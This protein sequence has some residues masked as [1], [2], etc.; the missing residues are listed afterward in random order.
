M[1]RDK[2]QN[3]PLPL[4]EG[5]RGRGKLQQPE[6]LHI[7]PHP[8]P[9]PSRGRGLHLSPLL[10]A[11]WLLFVFV[12]AAGAGWWAGF[13]PDQMDT[14]RLA[15]PPGM[16][17]LLGT[18]AMGRDIASR[19]LFGGRV[20]LIVGFCAPFV[21]LMAGL[22]LGVPAAF[23]RGRIEPLIMTGV[24]VLLAFPGLVF[25][26]V[27][28]F[29]F[30]SSLPTLTVGLGLL[31]APRFTRVARANTLRFVDREFVLAARA[32]GAGNLSI[33][34]R[35]ILPNVLPPL[36]IYMLLVVGFVIIAE[37]GLGFLGLSVPSPTPSWG[38]MMA[39]GREVL[40]QS[41]HVSMIPTG[42]MFLTVLSVNLIGDRLR[43]RF[44][45]R[46]ARP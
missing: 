27:F 24:D 10:A 34:I 28:T 37:G 43:R 46:D 41:P 45:G 29:A 1:G 42:V 33:L 4:R 38:G 32:S 11:G 31:T 44:E 30:G 20:S 3:S 8:N 6:L 26:L 15:S 17:H 14:A 22:L 25:L 18:D 36:L 16:G 21:G 7:H 19:L 35:E 2:L 39:E 9:P 23:Y 40:D 5:V 12:C 13:P